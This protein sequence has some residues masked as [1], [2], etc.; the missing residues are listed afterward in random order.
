MKKIIALCLMMAICLSLVA[1]SAG[2]KTQTIKLQNGETPTVTI[3]STEGY[4][5]ELVN[6]EIQFTK[7]GNPVATGRWQAMEF[8]SQYI[9]SLESEYDEIAIDNNKADWRIFQSRSTPDKVIMILEYDN[10]KVFFYA[11]S[12]TVEDAKNIAKSAKVK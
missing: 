8:Y 3:S 7:N 4:S 9:N 1:C 11:V 10:D 2:A 6:G 12:E 5:F